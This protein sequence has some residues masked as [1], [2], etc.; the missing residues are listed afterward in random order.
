MTDDARIALVGFGEAAH[1]F[2]DGWGLAGGGVCA[3]DLKLLDP[4]TTEAFAARCRAAGVVPCP[5]PAQAL[6]GA[7]LVLSL[8]TADQALAAAEALAR[9]IAPGALWLDGNS[10][11]PGAKRAAAAAVEDAGGRYVD[12]AIMAPVHPRRH[13]TPVLLAGPAAAAAAGRLAALGMV[14][15]LAGDRVG[16]ASTIKMLRSVM[17]K[18][19][20]ALAAEC[21]LAARRA[22]V[23]GPVLASLQASD[24]GFDWTARAAYNLERMMV[25]GTRRAAEMREV[26]ATLRELGLPDRLALATAEWQAQIGALGLAGG[27]DGLVGRADRILDR[28]G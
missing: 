17:V 21:V 11:S 9:H 22:G 23:E 4:A 2:L 8:V 5:D 3:Y 6:A 10:C 1:A 7:D 18:G 28:L 19:F 12:M 24:P 13:L 15:G 26:A 20:E 27:E 25:H 16:D 14:P